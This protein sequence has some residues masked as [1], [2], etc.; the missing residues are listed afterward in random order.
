MG[1][2]NVVD[3]RLGNAGRML[4]ETLGKIHFWML[5]ICFHTTFLVQHWL[6][7]NACPAASP[8]VNISPLCRDSARKPH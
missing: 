1:A 4:D 3:S 5:F 6:G 2:V 8:R 7:S